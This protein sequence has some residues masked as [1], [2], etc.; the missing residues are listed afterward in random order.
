MASPLVTATLTLVPGQVV[1]GL[2]D[3]R[4]AADLLEFGPCPAPC[5]VTSSGNGTQCRLH[6]TA[7]GAKDVSRTGGNAEDGVKLLIGQLIEHY[8]RPADHI[9]QLPGGDGNIHI[10]QAHGALPS[11]PI[12]NFLAVQGIT[13][14]TTMFLGSSPAFWA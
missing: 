10:G 9:R 3:A 4:N 6:H 14:T 11:R 2:L 1:L 7:G 8:T 13:L 5:P 12:S